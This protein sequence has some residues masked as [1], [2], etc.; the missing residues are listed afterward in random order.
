M[1]MKWVLR[2]LL[3]VVALSFIGGALGALMFFSVSWKGGGALTGI[4]FCVAYVLWRCWVDMPTGPYDVWPK[5]PEQFTFWQFVIALALPWCFVGLC[6][7]AVIVFL[8][9]LPDIIKAQEERIRG[10]LT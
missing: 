1:N 6:I 4:Y 9:F 10:P 8:V 7:T 3:E 2:Y 5:D